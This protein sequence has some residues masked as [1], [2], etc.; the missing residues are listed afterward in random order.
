[1]QSTFTQRPFQKCQFKF[2]SLNQTEQG[3]EKKKL[4]CLT[5]AYLNYLNDP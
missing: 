2:E 4:V 1:M 3:R 5:N